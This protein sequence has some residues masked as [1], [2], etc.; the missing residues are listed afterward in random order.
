MLA[1]LWVLAWA[2]PA[3][4]QSQLPGSVPTQQ[5]HPVPGGDNNFVSVSG[6]DVLGHLRFSAGGYLNYSYRPLVLDSVVGDRQVEIIEHQLQADLLGAIGLFDVLELGIRAPF[7]LYQQPGDSSGGL[8]APELS[9]LAA[10]AILLTAFIV[11]GRGFGVR[12]WLGSLAPFK[13]II[14]I[15][16]LL[17]AW[18]Y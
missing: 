10:L 15:I 17:N 6:T 18:F 12:E 2:V 11:A 1:A 7:T 9:A 16:F 4:A 13:L 8:S 14:P 5:F 3:P